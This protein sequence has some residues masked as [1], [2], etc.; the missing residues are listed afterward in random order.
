MDN[1]LNRM[2]VLTWNKLKVNFSDAS[3]FEIENKLKAFDSYKINTEG[4]IVSLV[5]VSSF[6]NIETGVGES[7]TAFV[8]K[9][10]NVSDY[11]VIDDVNSHISSEYTLNKSN[12]ILVDDHKY[13][14]KAGSKAV[15]IQQYL[16]ENDG[17]FRHIGQTKMYLE[18]DSD[19]L[20]VQVQFLNKNTQ[21]FSD[22]GIRLSEGARA[23]VIRVEMGADFVVSG[24]KATMSGDRSCFDIDT[25]YYGDGARSFDFNDVAKHL[26]KKTVSNIKAQGALFDSSKKVYR[27][28]IDFVRGSKASVGDEAENTLVFSPSVVN[29]SAPIILCAEHDVEGHHAASIGRIDEALMFY[30][31]TRGFEKEEVRQMM[32]ESN[33]NPIVDKIPNEPL[34]EAIFSCIQRRRENSDCR[35]N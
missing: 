13:Y 12:P 8:D 4:N 27:G 5:D 7:V 1:S 29:K 21:H 3:L 16:S 15:I 23:S 10:N 2:P 34:R 20:L 22:I 9:Y 11:S 17:D 32:I 18:K 24:C 28:T 19:V 26:G 6:N 30:M 25:L 14:F 31:Q 35:F 33:F